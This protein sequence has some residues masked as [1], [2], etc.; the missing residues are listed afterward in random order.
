MF[1]DEMVNMSLDLNLD[2]TLNEIVDAV[3]SS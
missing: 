1:C 3:M 2:T